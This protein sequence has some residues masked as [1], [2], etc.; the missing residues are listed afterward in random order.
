MAG[1]LSNNVNSL[2]IDIFAFVDEPDFI[3]FVRIADRH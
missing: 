2:K 1:K 3:R